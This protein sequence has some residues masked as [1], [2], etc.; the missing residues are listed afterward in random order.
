LLL[1]Y[2]FSCF[3]SSY[4]FGSAFFGVASFLAT[5]MNFDGGWIAELV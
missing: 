1:S 2:F 3:I 4:F 5:G